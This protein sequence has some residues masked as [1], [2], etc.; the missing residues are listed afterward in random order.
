MEHVHRKKEN[1][2]YKKRS[3]SRAPAHP[4]PLSEALQMVQ[5]DTDL[6]SKAQ[7]HF[8]QTTDLSNR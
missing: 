3:L 1:K 6:L 5:Q 2:K 7:G 8:L 4:S